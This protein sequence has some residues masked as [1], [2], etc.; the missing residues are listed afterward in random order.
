M[1]QISVNNLIS[2]IPNVDLTKDKFNFILDNTLKTNLALTYNYIVFLVLVE[3]NS[4]HKKNFN[5]SIFKNIIVNIASIIEALLHHNLSIYIKKGMI[6]EE[7]VMPIEQVFT[8]KKKIYKVNDDIEVLGVLSKN[9]TQKLRRN[10]NF[11]EVNRACLRGNIISNELFSKVEQIREKRNRVHLAG[12][13]EVDDYYDEEDIK[14][15][16]DIMLEVVLLVEENLTK[17]KK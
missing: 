8:D 17:G 16:F 2:D 13:E 15:G 1:E 7:K 12:L 11:L 6:L 14:E 5:Y 10:T 9:K 4:T 3:K